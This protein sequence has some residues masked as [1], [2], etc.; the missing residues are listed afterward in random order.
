M[1]NTVVRFKALKKKYSRITSC[2][3][4]SKPFLV[5]AG[6]FICFKRQHGTKIKRAGQSSPVDQE[7]PK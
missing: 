1:N 5:N 4:N 6:W 3:K 2:H 7:T